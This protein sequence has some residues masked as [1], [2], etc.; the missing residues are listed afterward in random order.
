MNR[1]I[2]VIGA[3]PAG[4]AAAI[5]AVARGCRVTLL[6]EATLPGGQIYRQAAPGR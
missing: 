5:E 6:D 4:M 2:V 1:W 3:G